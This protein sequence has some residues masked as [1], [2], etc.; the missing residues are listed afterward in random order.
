[1]F[2]KG[3]EFRDFFTSVGINP[4]DFIVELDKATHD[5]LHKGAD[6]WNAEWR[7]YIKSLENRPEP[8]KP[9]SKEEVIEFAKQLLKK[10]GLANAIPCVFGSNPAK[11]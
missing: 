10:K 8:D 1:V 2:P 4:H 9:V 5:A 11:P 6:N 3:E 7:R